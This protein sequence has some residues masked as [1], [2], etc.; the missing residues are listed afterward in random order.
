MGPLQAVLVGVPDPAP[1]TLHGRSYRF[2]SAP[3]VLEDLAWYEQWLLAEATAGVVLTVLDSPERTTRTGILRAVGRAAE[4]VR[5]GGCTDILLVLVGHGLQVPDQDD[6]EPDGMDEVFA[7]TDGPVLDDEFAAI[8]AGLPPHAR[9][10]A[11]ADTCSSDSIA[12][13]GQSQPERHILVNREGPFRLSLAAARQGQDAYPVRVPHGGTDRG[14]MSYALQLAWE[15]LEGDHT[16]YLRWFD[17]AARLVSGMSNQVPVL[18]YIG[19]DRSL[20]DSVPLR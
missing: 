4:A 11:L 8:W 1:F 10:V 5:A 7:A 13:A 2:A 14:V 18:R 6:D 19:P 15:G 3:G 20:L 16:T 9:V 17:E 12:I